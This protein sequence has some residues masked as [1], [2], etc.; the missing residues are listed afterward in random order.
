VKEDYFYQWHDGVGGGIYFAPAQMA[1][2]EFVMS[3]SSEGWYP[4]VSFG[5]RF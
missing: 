3:W 4:L 2:F 1:I 5:F